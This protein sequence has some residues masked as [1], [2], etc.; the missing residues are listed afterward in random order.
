MNLA[1]INPKVWL[2]LA[3]AALVVG[4]C[5]WGYSAIY[6]RGA[7]S[8]QVRWDAERQDQAEQS[9]KIAANALATTTALA[10]TIENQRNDTYAQI[11]TLNATVANAVIG[12]RNRP[13]RDSA[14]GVPINPATGAASGAT[15]ADLLRQDGEF[16]VRESARAD[17][18]R[19]Q[20]VQCQAQ[21][22]AAREALSR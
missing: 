9:A 18:L 21:Y 1:L 8:V 13:A 2:E 15:G 10:A 7:E 3:L 6:N 17:R 12:L 4:V 19:L 22:S 16:L 20:L 14:G 5:W 11:A